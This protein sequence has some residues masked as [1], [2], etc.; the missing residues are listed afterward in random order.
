[1]RWF[2]GKPNPRRADV[3]DLS[4]ALRH[5]QGVEKRQAAMASVGIDGPISHVI[6]FNVTTSA[7]IM[8]RGLG[9]GITVK[10]PL[11][12]LE[13]NVPISVEGLIHDSSI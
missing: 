9:G 12:L 5:R 1:V 3:V 8:A 6:P 10:M 7:G 11:L 4:I 2:L 13:H